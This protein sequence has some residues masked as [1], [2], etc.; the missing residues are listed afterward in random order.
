[1]MKKIEVKCTNNSKTTTADVLLENDK[2]MKV[3]FEGTQIAIEMFRKD[4]NN[5]Y[6]GHT[7]GLEFTWQPKN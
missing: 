4:V 7:A 6:I 2:H 1:M 3:V 5:P